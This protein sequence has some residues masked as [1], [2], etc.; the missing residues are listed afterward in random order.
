MATFGD[1]NKKDDDDDGGSDYVSY[2]MNHPSMQHRPRG[3]GYLSHDDQLE[4]NDLLED[5]PKGWWE[6]KV[7]AG[8]GAEEVV[9]TML[10]SWSDFCK[11]GLQ[12]AMNEARKF[13]TTQRHPYLSATLT[14][15]VLLVIHYRGNEMDWWR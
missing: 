15:L 8:V 10:R 5:D 1:Y 11:V 2:Q 9:S 12:R 4:N 14:V 7:H 6:K 13:V 3:G